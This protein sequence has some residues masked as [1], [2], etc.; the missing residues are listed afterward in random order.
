M[1]RQEVEDAIQLTLQ[2]TTVRVYG[3]FIFA[4]GGE[5]GERV[6]CIGLLSYI[7]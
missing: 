3:G 4:A 2:Q 7:T 5:I 6:V 1:Y